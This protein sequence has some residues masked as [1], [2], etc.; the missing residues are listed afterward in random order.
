MAGEE[1]ENRGNNQRRCDFVLLDV[2][3]ELDRIKAWHHIDR[4]ADEEWEVDELDGTLALSDV[5]PCVKR[6]AHTIDVVKGK[7]T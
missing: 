7:N 1:D 6:M 4:Q 3:A 5:A 2:G